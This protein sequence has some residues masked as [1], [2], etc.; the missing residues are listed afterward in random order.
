MTSIRFTDKVAPSPARIDEI[1]SR[2]DRAAIESFVLRILHDPSLADRVE[3]LYAAR[4]PANGS[5]PEFT[6]R[7][8]YEAAFWLARLSR[9]FP[10]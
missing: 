5:D 2:G 1:L 8:A 9:E 7:T 10:R 4:I 3:A 6:A